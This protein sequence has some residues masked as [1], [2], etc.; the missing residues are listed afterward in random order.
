MFSIE[1]ENNIELA[2]KLYKNDHMERY[3]F[4]ILICIIYIAVAYSIQFLVAFIVQNNIQVKSM[5][6]SFVVVNTEVIFEQR[7]ALFNILTLYLNQVIGSI[8]ILELFILNIFLFKNYLKSALFTIAL[9]S[10]MNVVE[11]VMFSFTNISNGLYRYLP[12]NS[13]YTWRSLKFLQ[14]GDLA[15]GLIIFSILLSIINMIILNYYFRR[16]LYYENYE[17]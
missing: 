10:M 8:F 13:E 3:I 4:K 6:L 14:F 2:L 1:Y 17:L 15:I 9:I 7:Y 16:N 12:L 5:D 11:Y